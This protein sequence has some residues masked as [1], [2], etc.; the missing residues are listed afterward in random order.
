MR[1]GGSEREREAKDEAHHMCARFARDFHSQ[2]TP[3]RPLSP[4]TQK[5]PTQP[6]HTFLQ[7]KKKAPVSRLVPLIDGFDAS[8]SYVIVAGLVFM[9]LSAP[10]VAAFHAP[11]RRRNRGARLRIRVGF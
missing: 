10:L 11:R 3:K 7:K 4:T 8:P 1:V 5:K 6:P 2:L 9:A